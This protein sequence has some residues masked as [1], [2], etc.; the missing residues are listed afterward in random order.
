MGF[1]YYLI[2][3]FTFWGSMIFLIETLH[4]NALLSIAGGFASAFGI[5]KIIS[6]V[7]DLVTKRT[8]E[9]Q[10]KKRTN[11]PEL[12]PEITAVFDRMLGVD[13][14]N[15]KIDFLPIQKEVAKENFLKLSHNVINM[16]FVLCGTTPSGAARQVL[17]HERAAGYL[18]GVYFCL[19]ADTGLRKFHKTDEWVAIVR[20]S[21]INIFGYSY[22]HLLFSAPSVYKGDAD[23]HE[24]QKAGLD[25]IKRYM[26]NNE[27]PL[28]LSR[29]LVL[30]LKE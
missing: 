18:S 26:D 13:K 1:L 22:G 2:A 9:K 15:N 16:V 29:I 23:F 20:E 4:W 17:V 3:L 10:R 8:C 25:D 14:D 28:G 7:E 27:P 12:T 30:G 21:Y 19:V 6:C 24:G 5:V 11:H